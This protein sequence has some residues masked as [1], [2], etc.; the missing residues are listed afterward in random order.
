VVGH[1]AW[2]VVLAGR[3]DPGLLGRGGGG[4]HR[5][6]TVAIVYFETIKKLD[7]K[8]DLLQMDL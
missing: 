6:I 7:N 3:G 4:G 5:K 2:R 1:R 8:D